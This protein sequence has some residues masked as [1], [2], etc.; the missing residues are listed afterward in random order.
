[1]NKP[2]FIVA[3]YAVI[4]LLACQDKKKKVVEYSTLDQVID[5]CIA[6][7]GGLQAWHDIQELIYSKS[8]DL[9]LADGSVEKS[10][11]QDHEYI[12]DAGLIKIESLQGED[13]VVNLQVSGEYSR[14]INGEAADVSQEAIHKAVQTSLYVIG[15]PFKLRDPGVSLEYQ[16]LDTLDTGYA[17]HVVQASYDSDD[18]S[19][20]T[21]SD[22]WKFYIDQHDWLV[23][24]NWVQ[25]SDHAN[26]VDNI[27]FIDIEGFKMYGKRE[28]YRL[29][30]LGAKDYLRA[31]YTYGDYRI[32]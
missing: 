25:S 12:Y 4:L 6:A 24:A 2:T 29:D 32:E 18:N 14:F 30:S 17:C 10:F 5:N 9:M 15:L 7:H 21:T 26:I 13:T 22:V 20:H 27:D 23:R 11:A 8:F 3:L 31:S 16:G 1:M 28:S 19:N